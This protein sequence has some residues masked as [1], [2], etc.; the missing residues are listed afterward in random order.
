MKFGAPPAPIRLP[1][2]SS[3]V[4]MSKT[5]PWATSTSGLRRTVSSIDRG[6]VTSVEPSSTSIS[7]LGVI[8]ASVPL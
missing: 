1:S 3:T 4:P 2:L 7:S 6:I 5:A 8:A